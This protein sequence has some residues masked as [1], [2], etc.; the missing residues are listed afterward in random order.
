[1]H[2]TMHDDAARENA[3][4]ISGATGGMR[5]KVRLARVLGAL[6]LVWVA[7]ARPLRAEE[8]VLR[9]AYA[10][11][12]GCSSRAA[13]VS[14]LMLRTSHVRVLDTNDALTGSNSVATVA[15]EL[16]DR[17]ASVLGELHFTEPDGAEITRAVTGTTCEEVVPALALI[18]ALLVDPEAAT[19]ARAVTPA[20]A[21][22]SSS[23]STPTWRFRPSIGAGV[24]LTTAVGPGLGLGPWVEIGIETE[25]RARRGPTLGLTLAHFRNPT[26]RTAAG[27]ADFS[28]TLGRLTLCP[29]RWPAS[30][31]FFG[32]AC[33]AFEAGSV[34]AAGSQTL[35][36]HTYTELWAALA[37]AVELSYRPWPFLSVRLDGLAVFPLVRD[38][39]YFGP[40][41]PVFSV[42]TVAVT[43]QAGLVAVWP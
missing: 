21:P 34:H 13:F 7:C 24:T 9:V 38:S 17:G 14:E 18:A 27:D 6:V 43:S 37:P 16:A 30:G 20:P 41:L 40:D 32:A 42:P 35:E 4:A 28:T 1:M 3:A 22:P 39:Y 12:A 19:R 33:G 23:S 8:R 5:L 31:L 26:Q 11:P 36:R 29:L 2:A 10:A 15:V 25:R